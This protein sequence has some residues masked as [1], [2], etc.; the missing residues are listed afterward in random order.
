[1]TDIRYVYY[2][3]EY[4]DRNE[5]EEAKHILTMSEEEVQKIADT[6][7]EGYRIGFEVTNKDISKK[8]TVNIRYHIGFERVVRRAIE[9][10]RKIGLEPTIYRAG[11]S[12]LRGR[13][14][15]KVGYFGTNP[16]KQFD[17]DHKED[18]ALFLD[19]MFITKRL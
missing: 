9:N 3:G 6:Y 17:F 2:Y 11:Q 15:F 1:M 5:L 7:T 13:D 8:K 12:L 16:N 14:V 4:I 10:F 18:L 19:K